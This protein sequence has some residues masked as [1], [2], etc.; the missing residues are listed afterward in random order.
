[1]AKNPLNLKQVEA[2]PAPNGLG[3]MLPCRVASETL[4]IEPKLSRQALQKTMGLDPRD[5]SVGSHP[6]LEYRSHRDGFQASHVIRN[7]PSDTFV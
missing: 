5:R 3:K 2:R 4:G 1:M 6:G 7:G